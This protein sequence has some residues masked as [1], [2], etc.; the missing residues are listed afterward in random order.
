VSIG[1]GDGIPRAIS[2]RIDFLVRGR[3]ARQ[4]GTITMDQC[5]IDVTD[6][7]EA[8]EGDITTLLGQD[9]DERIP[10]AEWAERLGTISYEILTVL[11]PRLPRIVCKS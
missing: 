6:V 3:R 10:V 11:S 5:L 7:P 1:Y 9:G 4:V 2:N 8:L